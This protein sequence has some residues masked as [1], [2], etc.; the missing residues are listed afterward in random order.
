MAVSGVG[1]ATYGEVVEIR[2]PGGERRRGGEVL[3]SRSDLAIVQVFGGTQDL[4][5]EITSVRF[6]GYPMRMVVSPRY[7]RPSI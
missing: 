2:L 6:T 5:T 7:H 1:D 4:D 3:E